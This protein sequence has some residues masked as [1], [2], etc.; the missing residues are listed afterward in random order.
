M[1]QSEQLRKGMVLA[2][3]HGD[4]AQVESEEVGYVDMTGAD[5]ELR[6]DYKSDSIN[7]NIAENTPFEAFAV[8]VADIVNNSYGTHNVRP[9]L[10]S[11]VDKLNLSINEDAFSDSQ[12]PGGTIIEPKEK[13]KKFPYCDEGPGNFKEKKTKNSVISN[14]TNLYE[15]IA[16]KTGRSVTEIKEIIE[17]SI[18]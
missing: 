12:Y 18:K 13:C 1:S 5:N 15:A 7:I 14:D 16:K 17:K 10:D 6:E 2:R 3:R 8:A 9:F 4:L 11:L